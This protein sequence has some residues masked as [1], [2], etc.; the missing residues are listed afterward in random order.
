VPRRRK[1][2]PRGLKSLVVWLFFG[3]AEA[4]PCY[5]TQP[6][7]TFSAASEAVPF[8]N[9]YLVRDSSSGES[10]GHEKQPQIL[11]LLTAFVAQDDSS[12]TDT[13]FGDW[14]L[15]ALA[16]WLVAAGPVAAG[17]GA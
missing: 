14:T 3:T 10:E 15:R 1:C 12:F 6:V 13:N 17:A 9:R 2:V 4:V 7:G 16:A 5:K 8:Q 11:R